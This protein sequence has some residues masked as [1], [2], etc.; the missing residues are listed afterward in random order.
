MVMTEFRVKP[1]MPAMLKTSDT[2][3][4][5]SVQVSLRTSLVK[6]ILNT[7]RAILPAA[8]GKVWRTNSC[9]A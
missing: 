2:L 9:T 1:V 6:R 7:A 4:V 5:I 3:I 8:H